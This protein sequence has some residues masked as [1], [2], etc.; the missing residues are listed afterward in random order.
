M[1]ANRFVNKLQSWWLKLEAAMGSNWNAF[2]AATADAVSVLPAQPTS[3]DLQSTLDRLRALLKQHDAGRSLLAEID[4][5]RVMRAVDDSE[6]TLSNQEDLNQVANRLR[7]IVGPPPNDPRKPVQDK[8]G[9]R[10]A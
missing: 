10:K 7:A 8:K 3:A 4:R 1:D 2:A 6:R 9:T 5:P